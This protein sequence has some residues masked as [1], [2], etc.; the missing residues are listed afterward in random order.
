VKEIVPA[1]FKATTNLRKVINTLRRKHK[2][3]SS[4]SLN[5]CLSAKEWQMLKPQALYFTMGHAY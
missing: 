1:S 2:K 4:Y 3:I 5:I